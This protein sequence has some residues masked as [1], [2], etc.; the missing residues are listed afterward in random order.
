[1]SPA[2][3]REYAIE[4]LSKKHDNSII[5]LEYNKISLPALF[6][7]ATCGYEW[8]TNAENVIRI[9]TGCPECAKDR[10]HKKLRHTEDYVRNLIES[11]GC[12]WISGEYKNASSKLFI[13]FPCGHSQYKI[14][15]DLKQGTGCYLC[16]R[17]SSAEKERFKTEDIIARVESFGYSFVEFPNGYKNALSEISYKCKY[18]HITTKRLSIFNRKHSCKECENIKRVISKTK[19]AEDVKNEILS[20]SC[21]W[22]DGEYKNRKSQLLI[23]FSCGHEQWIPYYLYQIRDSCECFE[24]T[25]EKA[26]IATRRPPEEIIKF[27][28]DSGFE[29]CG[30]I[31]EYKNQNTKINY[32]CRECNNL[33]T[34]KISDFLKNPTC[35]KCVKEKCRLLKIGE[36]NRLWKGGNCRISK[37]F[38]KFISDWYLDSLKSNN[39]KCIISG[40]SAKTIHHLHPFYKIVE[41]FMKNKGYSIKNTAGDFSNEE[42]QLLVKDFIVY[43]N[44][45]GLGVPLTKKVHRLFHKYYTTMNNTP[46]QFYEFQ[47]R[48]KSGDIVIPD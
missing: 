30:F 42:L 23:R 3:T 19:P 38:R 18:G 21:A 6:K 1:M 25:K 35:P 16:G 15:G 9:G 45:F 10:I 40:D 8:K 33:N 20:K 37:Y 47:Q 26:N 11:L 28:Q 44:S 17:L 29:F 41:S 39:Y 7:C 5:L 34:R 48:I 36:N 43:H 12:E 32:F 22:I 4:L 31:G 2:V 24:C 27:V 14:L 46:E 13:K